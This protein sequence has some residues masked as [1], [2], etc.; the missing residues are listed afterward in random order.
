MRLIG[1][2]IARLQLWTFVLHRHGYDRTATMRHTAEQNSEAP[3]VEL[4]SLRPSNTSNTRP[5]SNSYP[6]SHY[7]L[8]M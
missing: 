7:T 6:L 8:H 5:C 2:E 3:R 1:E 4:G